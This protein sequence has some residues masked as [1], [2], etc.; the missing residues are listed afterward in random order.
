[1]AQKHYLPPREVFDRYDSRVRHNLIAGYHHK[2]AQKHRWFVRPLI[3]H[4]RSYYCD[5]DLPQLGGI[6]IFDCDWTPDQWATRPY[7]HFYN[8]VQ[9][10]HYASYT[11]PG[12][13]TLDEYGYGYTRRDS[14]I[15][16]DG[17]TWRKDFHGDQQLVLW[18]LCDDTQPLSID[19]RGIWTTAK[20]DGTF[21]QGTFTAQEVTKKPNIDAIIPVVKAMRSAKYE[22]FYEDLAQHLIETFKIPSTRI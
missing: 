9:A 8:P 1:M 20:P 12:L 13:P 7:R 15:T 17:E 16:R 2:L 3:G 10:I 21:T 11:V 14:L 19:N 18:T 22:G 5:G 6:E 4:G